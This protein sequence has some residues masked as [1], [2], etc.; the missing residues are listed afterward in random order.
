MLEKM[1]EKVEEQEAL[2]DAYGEMADE[3]KSI[4]EEINSAL[5]DTAYAGTSAL[6]D[7][8]REMGLLPAEEKIEIKDTTEETI[9]I[10]VEKNDDTTNA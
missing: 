1:K 10:D 6:D 3:G 8:K 2:S 9:K 4:D 5:E 7:L